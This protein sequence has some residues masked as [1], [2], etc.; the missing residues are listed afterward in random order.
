MSSSAKPDVLWY[1][2]CGIPTPLGLAVQLGWLHDEFAADG[3]AIKSLQDSTDPLEQASHFEHTLPHSFRYGG[4]SPAIWA[5]ARG[6]DT[7]VIGIS[8]ID[9]YQAILTLPRSG[10]RS[11]SDLRGRRLGLPAPRGKGIDVARAASLRGF[12]TAL[13]LG[14]LGYNDVQWVD[15]ADDTGID[16]PAQAPATPVRRPRRH[17]YTLAAHALVRGDVD[18]IYVKDVRGAETAHLL[19]LHVAVDIGAHPDPQVRI[20]YCTPRPLTVN[21]ATLRD[22]PDIVVRVLAR[23][24]EAGRWARTHADDTASLIARETGWAPQWLRF[25]YGVNLN[26]NLE[27]TLSE[28]SIR[29]LE[30]FKN[31]LLQWKFIDADLDIRSWIDPAPFVTVEGRIAR[32]A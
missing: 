14:G 28:Q 5:R 3:I 4:S 17:S 16:E 26:R 8:W 23:V 10:I 25:A 18:A 1:T 6:Q 11:P 12:L 21:G 31:F 24:V 19:G 15:F 27:T 32:S 2:R 20:N 13:E 29:G 30:S 22:Y 9:E 7:R